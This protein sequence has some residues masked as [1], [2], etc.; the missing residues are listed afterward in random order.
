MVLDRP[1]FLK[2]RGHR[3]Q[4]DRKC[5][6][7]SVSSLSI[8]PF[9]RPSHLL[10]FQHVPT[11][12]LFV[13][14]CAPNSTIFAERKNETHIIYASFSAQSSWTAKKLVR[15]W[16][17]II[18]NYCLQSM[19]GGQCRLTLIQVYVWILWSKWNM[20]RSI[21]DSK[22]LCECLNFHVENFKACSR[23]VTTAI[24]SVITGWR[25]VGL[26][27]QILLEVRVFIEYKAT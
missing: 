21:E 11:S 19:W 10:A 23:K 14:C 26:F 18:H 27:L 8:V 15:K 7:A 17:P 1:Q 6:R 12:L 22:I 16:A 24:L 13:R 4:Y 20:F 9:R 3:R 2:I 25:A 5:Y